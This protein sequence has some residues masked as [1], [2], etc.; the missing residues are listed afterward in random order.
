MP[1]DKFGHTD[2]GPSQR[3]ISG[4]VTLTQAINTFLRRDGT[5]CASGDI[6]LD[7]HKLVNVLDP[8]NL[9]DAATK[10]YVDKN[11]NVLDTNSNSINKVLKRGDTMT[12]EL[13]LSVGT[14]TDRLLGCTDL[15]VGQRFTLALGNT[16]NQ[17]Q[18]SVAPP[19]ENKRPITMDTVAGF[20]VKINGTDICQFGTT[21]T[22]TTIHFRKN[23]KMNNNKIM[24]LPPPSDPQD[25]ATKLYVDSIYDLSVPKSCFKTGTGRIPNVAHTDHILLTFPPGKSIT[26]GRIR[27]TELWIERVSDE[28]FSTSCAQ[29][30]D[31]WRQF[32]RISRGPS[33]ICYFAEIRGSTTWTRN[34]RLDYIE[35]E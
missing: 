11:S 27:I 18:F 22:Q 21:G 19:G 10:S 32:H 8:I 16:R 31:D 30:I 6:N 4:G 1:V 23:L 2:V 15:A 33:L 12:G 14:G 34:Y 25:A 9:Q 5:S 24:L 29:F 35:L 17:I 7:S 3:V 20:R 26:N 28:W 13:R